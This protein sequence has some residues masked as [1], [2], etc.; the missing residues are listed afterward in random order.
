MQMEV[1]TRRGIADAAMKAHC[2]YRRCYLGEDH[3][4]ARQKA[5]D[6]YPLQSESLQFAW[7]FMFYLRKPMWNCKTQSKMYQVP[8]GPRQPLVVIPFCLQFGVP[9]RLF[10]EI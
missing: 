6:M 1:D 7:V 10:K 9:R 3:K 5:H 8:G 2:V 4:V